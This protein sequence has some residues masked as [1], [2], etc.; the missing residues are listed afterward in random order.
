MRGAFLK[1][2]ESFLSSGPAASQPEGSPFY[3]A[4]EIAS[5]RRQLK[6]SNEEA[7]A[8]TK[9]H[10]VTT[11]ARVLEIKRRAQERASA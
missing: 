1:L 3:S 9:R 7:L 6:A 4:S 10:G 11:N 5:L 2:K 8:V